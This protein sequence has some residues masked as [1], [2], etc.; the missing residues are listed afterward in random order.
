MGLSGYSVKSREFTVH[1]GRF[2][3]TAVVFSWK[4]ACPRNAV[5]SL[6][7]SVLRRH[8]PSRLQQDGRCCQHAMRSRCISGVG[9][10]STRA[11]Y[12]LPKLPHCR[13]PKPLVAPTGRHAT[14]QNVS[15]PKHATGVYSNCQCVVSQKSRPL[16]YC[17]PWHIT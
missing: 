17:L 3:M 1:S 5:V 8:T 9:P 15:M 13:Q 10:L 11:V 6:E 7:T 4:P 12:P 16:R 14:G 2:S